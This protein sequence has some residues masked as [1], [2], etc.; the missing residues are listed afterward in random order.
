[1]CSKLKII[2]ASILCV[3]SAAAM[4]DLQKR[5]ITFVKHQKDLQRNNEEYTG[6]ITNPEGEKKARVLVL[7]FPEI[8]HPFLFIN[9]RA[10]FDVNK[11]N[12]WFEFLEKIYNR[13]STAE[14]RAREID[15]V[16]AQHFEPVY[17]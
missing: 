16:E 3:F 7:K 11:Q 8:R 15:M 4:Q 2:L 5:D 14:G 6:F 9:K 12:S 10:V 1:M 13:S 17:R